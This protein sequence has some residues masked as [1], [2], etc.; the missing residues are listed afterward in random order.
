MAP[1]SSSSSCQPR[2]GRP[3]RCRQRLLSMK[4]GS[5]ELCATDGIMWERGSG[6]GSP[7]T[8]SPEGHPPTQSMTRWT[9]LAHWLKSVR[10]PRACR[11]RWRLARR[12]ACR[13][14]LGAW[15]TSLWRW[16]L[17]KLLRFRPWP[18]SAQTMRPRPARAGWLC[19]LISEE[20]LTPGP[21]H[22]G[23]SV[24]ICNDALKWLRE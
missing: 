11:G 15:T 2:A 17:A 5:G 23:D 9:P 22:A 19:D 21:R 18:V 14:L 7:R 13:G 1:L 12:L 4:A 24:A 10:S 3:R 8:A 6:Y 20:E 16:R